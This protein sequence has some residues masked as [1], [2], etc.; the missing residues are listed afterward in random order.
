MVR[1]QRIALLATMPL[2][3][4]GCD[5]M[6][7]PVYNMT[8]CAIEISTS[9][10]NAPHSFGEPSRVLPGGVVA[11]LGGD[12]PV[13]YAEIVIHNGRNG[14]RRYD[15]GALAALRPAGISEDRWAYSR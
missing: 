4:M 7:A 2:A 9:T 10:A 8:S 11:V 12:K 3:C 14:D 1:L 5:T 15:E 13:K 6:H